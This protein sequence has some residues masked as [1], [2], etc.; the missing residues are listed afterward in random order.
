M[1]DHL[2]DLRFGLFPTPTAAD[3]DGVVELAV[4]AESLG[5]DLVSIQDHPY[6]AAHADTWTLLSAIGARTSTLRLST[7]V[8]NVP[9]R[10]PVVLARSAATL[11]LLTHGRVD[12]GLGTGAFWDAIE[13]AGGT[14]L[15]AGQSVDALIEAIDV[16]RQVWRGEGTVR[17]DGEHHRV[18]GL[19][20]GPAPAHP[21]EIW[22]GAYGPRML[23]VT[24]R[25]A[26]GWVPSMGYADPPALGDLNARVD[27]AA[28][29]AGRDPAA[30]RRIYNIFGAFGRSADFLRGTPTDW[31]EQLAGLAIDEGMSTF[32]LGTDDPDIL[33]RFAA[34]VAPGVRELVEAERARED[35]DER[36][37]DET[38]HHLGTP[39]RST[40]TELT[41]D[42]A[43]EPVAV[44]AVRPTPDDGVRLTGDLP[45]D[46]ASRPRAAVPREAAYTAAQQARPQH[47]I[48]VHDQLRAELTQLRDVVDQVRRGHLTVGGARSVINT[49]SLR[50]N[51]WS[52][53]A[54]CESYCRIVTGHHTLEDHSV[55][56]HLVRAD[57]AIEPVIERLVEE[58]EVIAET[59]EAVDRA[60]VDLV[61]G[62]PYGV[63][64]RTRL[65]A[66]QHAIDLLTDTLLSHLAYEEREL[67]HPLAR[68]GFQ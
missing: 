28:V 36:D 55:F 52:L 7:N 1:P 4:L 19:K 21:I 68:H 61:T 54:Y 50:Q 6:Q 57:P 41:P 33:R 53:G 27:E 5:L 22:L 17:V 18:R 31:V 16:I 34:E 23:R 3:P 51:N 58:H 9:L 43:A 24:G 29:A 14:R 12:L 59:L 32:I 38:A 11:D 20:S 63:E 49:M 46:E 62:N 45:W 30:I 13:A 37:P 26:D 42:P 8:A 67:L 40:A 2:Q 44:G 10:P 66:L 65:D 39:E 48:D 60:L 15:A 64:G 35:G 56:T 47:L 25:L